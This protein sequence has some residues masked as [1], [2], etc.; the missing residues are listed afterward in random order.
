[1]V[2]KT[3][4]EAAKASGS[5]PPTHGVGV[6]SVLRLERHLADECKTFS[7]KPI[8]AGRPSSLL[9]WSIDYAQSRFAGDRLCCTWDRVGVPVHTLCVYGWSRRTDDQRKK[10][11]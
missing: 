6:H 9:R 2:Y 1:M 3:K 11:R 10:L 7:M 4:Q 8:L 5:L